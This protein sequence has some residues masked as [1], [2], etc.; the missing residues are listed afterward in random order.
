MRAGGAWP[1][2]ARLMALPCAGDK[3]PRIGARFAAAGVR[4]AYG[5]SSNVE[6]D[7]KKTAP[8]A[9]LPPG[10]EFVKRIIDKSSDPA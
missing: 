1:D 10:G 7:G 6:I 2:G 9:A 3:L 4:H 8:S 5:P